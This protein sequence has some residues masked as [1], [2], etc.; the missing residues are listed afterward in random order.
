M[1]QFPSATGC[2]GSFYLSVTS[3]LRNFKSFLA[4]EWQVIEARYVSDLALCMECNAF[5]S[6]I[7][8]VRLVGEPDL[9]FRKKHL[10]CGSQKACNVASAGNNSKACFLNHYNAT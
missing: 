9:E 4:Q 1:K 7:R 8:I 3:R 2:K 6:R 10:A 5:L